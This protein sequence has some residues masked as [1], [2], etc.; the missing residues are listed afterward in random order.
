MPQP[1]SIQFNGLSFAPRAPD[2]LEASIDL[3]IATGKFYVD[4]VTRSSLTC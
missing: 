2:E 1:I 3:E 4:S